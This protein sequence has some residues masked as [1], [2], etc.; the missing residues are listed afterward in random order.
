LLQQLNSRILIVEIAVAFL[1]DASKVPPELQGHV[2]VARKVFQV[3]AGGFGLVDFY[4]AVR[5]AGANEKGRR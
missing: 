5:I 2:A 4:V 1:R 3:F